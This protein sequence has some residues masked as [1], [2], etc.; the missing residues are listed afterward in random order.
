MNKK[1][2]FHRLKTDP[3]WVLDEMDDGSLV[4]TKNE[5]K[6]TE[7]G[8]GG[9]LAMTKSKNEKIKLS[10]FLADYVNVSS[11]ITADGETAEFLSL[12]SLWNYIKR[13]KDKA[14]EVRSATKL[15]VLDL[16]QLADGR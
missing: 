6:L 2:L 9:S 13:F 7:T 10:I 11:V 3:L 15:I 8:D 1:E 4:L 14:F 16:D 5:W 12:G